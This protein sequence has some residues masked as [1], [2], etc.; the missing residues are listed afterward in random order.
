M[1]VIRPLRGGQPVLA[2]R[3]FQA[4]PLVQR[5]THAQLGIGA[6]MTPGQRVVGMRELQP[7]ALL[8]GHGGI[9]F[10]PVQRATGARVHIAG[11]VGIQRPVRRERARPARHQVELAARAVV[12]PERYVRA[13]HAGVPARCDGCF[14][15]GLHRRVT[16]AL[17][18]ATPHVVAGQRRAATDLY[19]G[20]R[21]ADCEQPCLGGHNGRHRPLAV[22][23][24]VFL[25]EGG[26]AAGTAVSRA[27]P[28]G[29]STWARY[30][31][32]LFPGT[33][34]VDAIL[35]PVSI[36]ELIDKI[37]I[38]E[39]KAERI[40]DAAKLANV[41][42]ELDGLLPLLQQQLQAQPALAALKQQL[43]VINERMWDIQDQLRDKEAAQVFDDAFIQLARGVYGTNGER[44][45]VKNEINRVAG[46]ALVEEKQYQGE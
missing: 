34:H 17:R 43:K 42:T 4:E 11:Q 15:T 13:P 3:R 6:A 1:Q 10:G 23:C 24:T 19:L 36:G 5:H 16:V 22:H 12:R 2:H 27:G 30:H 44:V 41:R 37:T 39:I 38:L 32:G 20:L 7:G 46:S 21:T 26:P 33:N 18:A 14:R 45:Q 25:V 35:T 28:G 29:A 31:A 8:P 9:E 40:G